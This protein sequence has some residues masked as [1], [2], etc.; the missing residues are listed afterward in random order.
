M[1]GN[2]PEPLGGILYGNNSNVDAILRAAAD[3][4]RQR[5]RDVLG[6]LQVEIADPANCCPETLLERIDDG[7]SIRISQALGSG[8]RGCRLDPETLVSV[9]A[10]M[11]AEIER[12]PDLVIINRFG[13]AESE[14]GGLRPVFVRAAELGI[15]VL[16]ALKDGHRDAWSDFAGSMGRLLAPDMKAI[17]SW[18]ATLRPNA[19]EISHVA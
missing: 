11:L 12:R 9:C 1:T 17:D 3:R 5:N 10:S 13:K 4:F 7:R 18:Y 19:W 2:D 8:A 15:P 16:T 6:Y 14:G